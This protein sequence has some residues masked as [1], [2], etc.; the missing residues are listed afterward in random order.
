LFLVAVI[1]VVI[2]ATAVFT[3]AIAL[4]VLIVAVEKLDSCTFHVAASATTT[5][6]EVWIASKLK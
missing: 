5:Q 4:S 6:S 2:T 1:A 3:L